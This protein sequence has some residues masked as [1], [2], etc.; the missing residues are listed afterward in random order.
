MDHVDFITQQWER[1][2]PDLDVTAM[3]VIGRVARLYLAYQRGMHTTFA[4]FG[5]NAA[6]FDVLATLRRSG[7][8][9]T[10]SPGELLKATMVASGTMTNRID[11]LEADGLVKRDVNPEDSRSF[12]VGLTKE[13]LALVDRAV[14]AH[15]QT[16]A[17][18]LE[19]LGTQE[20]ETFKTLLSKAQ[21]AADS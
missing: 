20:V 13:G 12:L 14:T 15:V 6:K 16:Q 8:P 3:G 19:G 1:E 5:L 4:E 9:Y 2:R 21:A 7:D 11:R 17:R 18:L 10:L